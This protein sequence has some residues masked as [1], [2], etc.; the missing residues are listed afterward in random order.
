MWESFW[1][2]QSSDVRIILAGCRILKKK[3]QPSDESDTYGFKESRGSQDVKMCSLDT[4][5]VKYQL[6]V[7]AFIPVTT[8]TSKHV[9]AKWYGIT[10]TPD[11]TQQ[12]P[13]VKP[14]R[15]WRKFW[16]QKANLCFRRAAHVARYEAKRKYI[17][18]ASKWLDIRPC[19]R[20]SECG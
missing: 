16:Y 10:S 7:L 14:R 9:I 19:P 6:A 4:H 12:H 8:H 5:K 17:K 3:K 11:K 13:R 18:S 20:S 2:G 15:R 1:L